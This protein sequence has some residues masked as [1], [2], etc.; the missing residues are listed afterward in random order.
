MYTI[1][2]LMLFYWVLSKFKLC[3][4]FSLA[5]LDKSRIYLVVNKKSM[6]FCL[7]HFHLVGQFEYTNCIFEFLVY[8][9][10]H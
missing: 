7:F 6:L 2:G 8:S 3:A 4:N 1:N 9:N 5:I 10:F